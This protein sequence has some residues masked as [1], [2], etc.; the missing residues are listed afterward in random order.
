MF[1]CKADRND[2]KEMN[3]KQTWIGLVNNFKLLLQFEL[4]FTNVTA[5][6]Y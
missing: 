3:N 5:Q 1:P 2:L 6:I 4:L